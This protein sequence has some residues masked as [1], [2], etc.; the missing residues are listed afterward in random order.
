[1]VDRRDK[2]Y[3]FV[4]DKHMQLHLIKQV[5]SNMGVRIRRAEVL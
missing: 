2:S 3:I 4:R 1:M 5:C